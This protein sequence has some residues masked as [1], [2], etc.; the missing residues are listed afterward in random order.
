[1]GVPFPLPDGSATETQENIIRKFT[2]IKRIQIQAEKQLEATYAL[3]RMMMRQHF[4]FKE[5]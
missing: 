4:D 5:D 2:Q 3:E 1:L